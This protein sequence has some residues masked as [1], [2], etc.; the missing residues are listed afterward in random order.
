MFSNFFFENFSVYE[1]MWKHIEELRRPQMTIWRMHIAC[2]IPKST[3]THSEYVILIAFP[4][5]QWLHEHVSLLHYTYI[6]C[7]L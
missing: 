6:V 1:V 4:R 7:L 2:W 5:Q 3:K